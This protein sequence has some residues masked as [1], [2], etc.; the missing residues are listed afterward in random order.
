MTFSSSLL[1]ALKPIALAIVLF[2]V[3]A[4]DLSFAKNI[5]VQGHRGARAVLPENSIPAFEYA[6]DIGVDT[7]EFDMGVTR[8]GVVVVIHD[9]QINPVICQ[10]KDGSE[11]APGLLVHQLT[12][13]EIKE[14]DCGARLNP[15]FK[16]QRLIP[17]TE[18]PTLADVFDLVRDSDLAAA[19]TVLFNIETKSDPRKPEAQPTPSEFVEAVVKVVREY[20]FEKRTTLQ[21]FDHRTLRAAKEIAPELRLAALFKEKPENWVAAADAAEADIVS[22]HFKLINAKQVKEMQDAGL[23]V[24]PW[25]ANS[26][27][28][29]EQ[30]VKMGVDGIISD[31]PEPLL[32]F[33]GR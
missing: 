14:F 1:T 27:R 9:Q 31:D 6:L 3:M 24:I 13:K 5:D 21:S 22:P 28:Q 12:L 2:M 30:L 33:L 8:D 15:R 16:N 23:A 20:G 25:T 18:I 10:R 26:K 19:K 4:I 17:G 7:L 11:V 29:W 32:E